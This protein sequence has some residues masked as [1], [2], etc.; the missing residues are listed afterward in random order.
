MNQRRE[1]RSS[2]P[3]TAFYVDDGEEVEVPAGSLLKC[4]TGPIADEVAAG[5]ATGFNL[6]DR[7]V[8][9]DFRGRHLRTTWEQFH[10]VG[11]CEE[12]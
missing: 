2:K 9:F 12:I 5:D 6:A 11:E 7:E 1:W 4:V 10:V 8:F 3:F